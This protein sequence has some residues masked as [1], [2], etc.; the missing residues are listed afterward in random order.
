[1]IYSEKTLKSLL[2][3]LVAIFT[4]N[5]LFVFAQTIPIDKSITLKPKNMAG[6]QLDVNQSKECSYPEIPCMTGTPLY[7]KT[8]TLKNHEEYSDAEGYD[9]MAIV[10]EALVKK[11]GSKVHCKSLTM[12]Q[13]YLMNRYTPQYTVLN[14]YE[15]EL[16]D[17]ARVFDDCTDYACPAAMALPVLE[18]DYPGMQEVRALMT[19][20]GQ[21]LIGEPRVRVY[22]RKGT[23]YVQLDGTLD[24]KFSDLIKPC[25]S[26][27]T[28][29]YENEEASKAL[30][31]C[32]DDI[33]RTDEGLHTLAKQKV[34]ELTKT[35][36]L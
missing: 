7:S 36:A 4:L 20:D 24:I 34:Q 1:M 19:M 10:S 6:I 8:Y 5:T 21:D 23:Q 29:A 27:Q 12:L 16:T 28:H 3:L 25:E 32:V 9:R 22:A 11:K 35:F 15:T 33:V 17:M 26:L 18:S 14:E 13:D 31:Q 2:G 30:L